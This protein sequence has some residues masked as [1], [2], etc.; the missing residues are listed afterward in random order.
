MRIF[1]EDLVSV[2]VSQNAEAGRV[3][4]RASVFEIDSVNGLGSRVK[5]KSKS[6]LTFS[7]RLFHLLAAGNDLSKDENSS[8]TA[9]NCL[10]RTNLPSRP[11]SA[12]LRLPTVFVCSQG[13]SPK[14]AAVN[15]FPTLR[16]S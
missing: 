4:E 1:A 9:F 6:V 16:L 15:L 3:A 12:V 8:H 14:S 5:K 2:Y 10:P 13:F 7:E 11:M